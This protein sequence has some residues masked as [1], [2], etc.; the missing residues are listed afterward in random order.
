MDDKPEEVSG[1]MGLTAKTAYMKEME[2][3]EKVENMYFTRMSMTKAQKK[4]HRKMMAEGN[5]DRLDQFDELK[6]IDMLLSG[7]SGQ[8]GDGAHLKKVA[9]RFK[10]K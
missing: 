3:L 2:E 5:Q 9:K 8:N 4:Y 6:D 1:A 7:N 10:R